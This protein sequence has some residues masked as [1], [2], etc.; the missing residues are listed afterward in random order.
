MH[1]FLAAFRHYATFKGR[2]S[3]KSFWVYQLIIAIV[4]TVCWV[5]PLYY[6]LTH[7]APLIQNLHIDPN[8]P[9]ALTT[10]LP[11]LSQMS[12]Q[13]L[14]KALMLLNN[15]GTLFFFVTLIPTLAICARRLHDSDN[16]AALLWLILVPLIGFIIL[17]VYLT[18][19]GTQGNNKYGADPRDAPDG[20]T[21]PE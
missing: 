20:T 6:L 2:T 3:V 5:I 11:Q 19:E 14:P 21:I 8:N 16:S 4:S 18:F 10:Q 1:Y 17:I 9:Q 7:L 12:S 15:I 13:Q